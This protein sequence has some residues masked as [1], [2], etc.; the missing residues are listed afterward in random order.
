MFVSHESEGYVS[1]SNGGLERAIVEPDAS[2]AAP[3]QMGALSFALW[4][5]PVR[6][7]LPTPPAIFDLVLA[8][9]LAGGGWLVWRKGRGWRSGALVLWLLA[10]AGVYTY[11]RSF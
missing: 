9:V 1:V 2:P 7:P 5:Q 10:L 8:I 4:F 6:D 3:G 11:I